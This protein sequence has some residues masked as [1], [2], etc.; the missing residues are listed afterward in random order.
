MFTLK[1]VRM[2]ARRISKSMVGKLRLQ[3]P[4]SDFKSKTY[5]EAQRLAKEGKRHIYRMTEY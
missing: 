2:V 3:R 1:S 5:D 4:A